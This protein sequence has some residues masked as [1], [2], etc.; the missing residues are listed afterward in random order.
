MN[1]CVRPAAQPL[2]T[3]GTSRHRSAACRH[4]R[5]SRPRISCARPHEATSASP[6][7]ARARTA[8]DL[9]ARLDEQQSSD[10]AAPSRQSGRN[11]GA[12]R[13]LDDAPKCA[14]LARR[15]CGTRCR[16]RP[17]FV[18]ARACGSRNRASAES[19]TAPPS[20][21]CRWSHWAVGQ[22][23]VHRAGVGP[24]RASTVGYGSARGIARANRRSEG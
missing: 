18:F 24:V 13:L 21:A 8:A 12:R 7:C 22:S 23:G 17:A 9:T 11:I 2:G 16:L 14:H 19:K 4:F 20:R 15:R 10:Q 6:A 1:A 5:D 3:R